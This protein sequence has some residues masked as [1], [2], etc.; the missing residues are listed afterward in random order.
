M[1][2]YVQRRLD[3]PGGREGAE[4]VVAEAMTV[5]WRR[6]DDLPVDPDDA[7][8]WLFGIARTC[9]L[10]HRR[11]AGRRAALGVRLTEV[12]QVSGSGAPHPLARDSSADLVAARVDLARAW[13]ALTEGEQDVLALAVFEGLDSTR[14][15]RVLGITAVA[16]RLRLSRARAQLRR[17]LEGAAS[18]ANATRYE[19]IST[20]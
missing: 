19:E 8:A 7:R 10:N 11:A 3:G 4:D 5:A 17:R 18:H 16:Y 15:G 6:V 1:L 13:S 12:E 20:C 9:L 14:A 2:R